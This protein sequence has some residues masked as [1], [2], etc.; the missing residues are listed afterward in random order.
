MK[1]ALSIMHMSHMAWVD[2]RKEWMSWLLL[3]ITGNVI[4]GLLTVGVYYC[5]PER[6]ENVADMIATFFSAIYTAILYQNGLDV[7][8]GRKL[9]FA[10]IS[11]QI[12]LASLFFFV[13]M[14]SYNP[15]FIPEYSETIF[16]FLPEEFAFF[17]FINFIVHLAIFYFILR[18]VFVPMILL[19]EKINILD[20]F[21]KSFALTAHHIIFIFMLFTYLIFA[22]ALTMLITYLPAMLYNLGLINYDMMSDSASTIGSLLGSAYLIIA[23]MGHFAVVAYSI[24][25]KSLAFKQLNAIAK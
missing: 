1:K 13:V 12:L 10:I 7:V 3:M 19:H 4:L 17:M 8:Y 22:L 18:F 23:F 25:M 11:R 21:R 9:S 24:L 2:F 15:F 20:A 14:L 6:F 16:F 5:M